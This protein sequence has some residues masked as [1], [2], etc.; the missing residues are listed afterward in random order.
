MNEG[1]IHAATPSPLPA[2]TLRTQGGDAGRI[3]I[4]THKWI[5][6]TGG[7]TFIWRD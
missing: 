4:E 2:R 1:R 7:I 5:F 6:P 3:E